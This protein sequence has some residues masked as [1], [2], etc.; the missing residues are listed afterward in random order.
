MRVIRQMQRFINRLPVLLLILTV[1]QPALA[2]SS[3]TTQLLVNFPGM[4]SV[5]VD[6]RVTDGLADAATGAWIKSAN[7]Q[8]DLVE[9][10][11]PTGIYDLRLRR[12]SAEFVVDGVDCSGAGDCVVDGITRTLTVNFPGMASVHTDVRVSDGAAGSYGDSVT[13]ANYQTDQAQFTLFPQDR[14]SV[15]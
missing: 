7:Y 11:V 5:H 3:G 14:K 6:V 9:I 8:S 4:S 15:V 2:V 12:G 13:Y 10:E 1:T